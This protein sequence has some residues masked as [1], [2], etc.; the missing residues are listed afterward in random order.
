MNHAPQQ[1]PKDTK[2][3]SRLPDRP[4]PFGRVA[5]GLI[6]L[7]FLV[8]KGGDDWRVAVVASVR[9]Q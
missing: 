1:Q 2:L 5:V 4:F 3:S 7:A 9:S 6:A 8:W